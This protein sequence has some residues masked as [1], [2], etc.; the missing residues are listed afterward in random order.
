MVDPA[1]V[2]QITGRTLTTAEITY[3]MPDHPAVLQAF[4]WQDYDHAP[5]FP[6]L[7]RFLD[8]WAHNLDGTL[9]GVRV[10]HRDLVKPADFRFVDG[11][12]VL[13]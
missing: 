11:L 2:C 1:F 6:R 7:C 4:I 9:A 10:A 3:H 8:F 13:N 5:R 12:L